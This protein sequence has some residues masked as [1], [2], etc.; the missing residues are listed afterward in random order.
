LKLTPYLR[1]TVGGLY[2]VNFIISEITA[3]Y[4]H[5]LNPFFWISEIF[6]GLVVT[7]Y[8]VYCIKQGLKELQNDNLEL[9]YLRILAILIESINVL[10]FVYL[11]TQLGGSD[12][13]PLIPNFLIMIGM[14]YLLTKNLRIMTGK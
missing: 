1:F 14:G 6:A 8:A 4:E 13:I 5:P 10:T 11:L 3:T 9:P 12:L 7:L 2:A